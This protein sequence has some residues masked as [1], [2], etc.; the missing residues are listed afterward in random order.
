MRKWII[1]R[2]IPCD[3]KRPWD[4]S[5]G[6]WVSSGLNQRLYSVV[7]RGGA[8]GSLAGRDVELWEDKVGSSFLSFL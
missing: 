6:G 4:H 5:P 2:I 7:M 3:G 8:R 1:T